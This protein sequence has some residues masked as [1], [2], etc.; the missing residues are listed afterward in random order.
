[1]PSSKPVAPKPVLLLN[2]PNLN[3]LG[4]REPEKYGH[5]TLAEVEALCVKMGQESGLTVECRQSN[6]E[7]ELITWVQKAR[8]SHAAIIIN[9]G[10]YSHT[11]VALLDALTLTQLPIIEV[12][13][14]N[15]HAREAFRQQSLLSQAAKAVIC[16]CGV[17][18]YAY[19]MQTAAKLLK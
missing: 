16:G 18:G 1:M 3:M 13:I 2:G 15:I 17:D 8:D 5:A 6:D 19:A 14:T 12:H 9:A 7:G 11:S 4:V 10:G